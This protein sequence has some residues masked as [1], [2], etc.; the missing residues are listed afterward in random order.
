MKEMTRKLRQVEQE[1]SNEKGPLNLFALFERED[2]TDLWDLVVSA[3]W[4][5]HDLETLRYI[6]DVLKRHLVGEDMVRLARI[7]ILRAAEDPVRAITEEYDV[8]HGQ[9]E[10]A[11]LSRF[12]MPIKHGYIFTARRAA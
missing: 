1:L 11:E 12:N 5:R 7:V 9:G 6:N 3:P 4:A 2:L 10:F 8:E